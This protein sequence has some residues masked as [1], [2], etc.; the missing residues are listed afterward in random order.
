MRDAGEER[1]PLPGGDRTFRAIVEAMVPESATLTEGAWSDVRRI[2]AVALRKRSPAV[3]RQLGLLV[4][5]LQLVALVRHGRTL[6]ALPL[7]RRAA[8]LEGLSRSRLVLLRR[9]IWGVR[10]LAFMGYYARPDAALAIGYR[11]SKAGW[12]ARRA[13]P[14]G[15]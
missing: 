11:A 14:R 6:R 15:G 10:T 13:V 1:V 4:G 5:L 7:A 2:V 12:D 8:L 9:G 3:R